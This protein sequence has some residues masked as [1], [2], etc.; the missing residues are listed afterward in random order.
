MPQGC[1]SSSCVT[2]LLTQIGGLN[3]GASGIALDGGGN[4]YF[5]NY[6]NGYVYELPLGCASSSCVTTLGSGFG[7]PANLAV[8]GSGNVY[9]AAYCI[10][11]NGCQ[12]VKEIDR[13]TP[14]ALNFPTATPVGSVDTTD[15]TQTVQI[16]NVGSAA[17]AFT[18]L[19]YPADFSE[20]SGDASACTGSTSLSAGQEC[21]LAI[22]FAPEKTGAPLSEDVTLTD[23]ALN[24]TGAQQ[25]VAVSGTSTGSI[26][27]THLSLSAPANAGVGA[28]FSITVTALDASGGTATGYA[29]TVSFTSTDASAV[30][31]A[32]SKLTAG[33][34][35][36]PVTLKTLGNQTITAA[37][38]ANSFTATSGTIDVGATPPGVFP[39]QGSVNFGSQAIGSPSGAQT[40]SFSIGAGTTVGSIAVVTQGAANLDFTQATGSTCTAT[41]YSSGATCV[42]N[43][44]FTPKFAGIRYGAVV[45]GDG[46]GNVLATEY[47]LGTGT[48]PQVTFLPGTESTMGIGLSSPGQLAVD[49]SGNVYLTDNYSGRILKETS[50]GGGYTQ[51]VILT[52]E[53]VGVLNC[54][55]AVAV[56]GAGNVYVGFGLIS[57]TYDKSKILKMTPSASGY[58]LSTIG[59][60]LTQAQGLVVDGNGNV[61]IADYISDGSTGRVVEE[62]LSADGTYTQSVVLTAG[63]GSF[64]GT[65]SAVAVDANGN[66]FVSSYY[67]SQV[68]ELT[69]SSG[70][71]TQSLIGSGLNWPDQMVT[72][73]EGNLYIADGNNSRIVKETLMAGSYVQSTVS[74]SGTSHPWGVAV[75]Q[76]GNV[77]ASDTYNARLLKEDLADA[78]SLSFATTAVGSTS[79]DSPKTAQ[80]LNYGNE[81]LALTALTYPV[82]FPAASGDASACTSSTSLSAGQECDLPIEFVPE[83]VGSPLSEDVTLTDNALNV[84]GAQQSIAVSGTAT[85]SIVA[86]HLSVSAPANVG[87]GVP[88]NVTVTALD[89]SGGTATGYTGT[90]S[91]TSTDASA[92]LPAASKLTAGVGSFPVTLKT[93][94]NQTITAKDAANAFTATSGTI[95]VG[96]TPPTPGPVPVFG[97]GYVTGGPGLAP[98]GTADGNYQLLSCPAGACGTKP[99]VTLTDQYPFNGTWFANTATA[100]WIGP[101]SG[102]NEDQVDSPGLYDYQESF[103][104]TGFD[105]NTVTLTGSYATDNQGYMQLNGVTAGPA[106]PSFTS[107]T[108]FTLTSGFNQ[109]INTL[110]FFVTNGPTGGLNPTGLFVELSGT[111]AAA[112]I[113]ATHFSVTTTTSVVAGS[114]F[115]IT[116]SALNSYGNAATT[117]N[118][119][120]SFTSSDP[121][122]VNPGPLTLA[123]GLGQTTVTLKTAGTQTITATDTTT[124]TLTG[125]GSFTVAGGVA[126]SV[127]LSN[128]Q[129]LA[130]V[131]GAFPFTVTAFD[132]YGNAT[133]AQVQFSSTDAGAILPGTSTL[134]PGP[135]IIS[136]TLVTT[137][138]QTITV[139]DTAN[140]S[141][142][143]TSGPILVKTP[144]LVVTTAADDA[145]VAGNCTLQA[146]TTTGTDAA[147]SLRDALLKANAF[148]A[149]IIS[150]DATKFATPQTITL[151]SAGTLTIS[152]NTSITGP[153]TGAGATLTNL[154]TVSGAGKHT[155]FTVTPSTTA[156][157]LNDLTI[158]HGASP[159]VGGGGINNQGSITVNNSTFSGNTAEGGQG[160]AIYNGNN[161]AVNNSTFVG[162]TANGTGGAGGAIYNA[163]GWSGL[164]MT[165]NDSTFTGN[166]STCGGAIYDTAGEYNLNLN[167]D[168][169]VG[170]T[171]GCAGGVYAQVWEDGPDDIGYNVDMIN[172]IVSGNTSPDVYGNWENLGGNLV[173]VGN[174]GLTPLANYGGPT[175]TMIP[176]P[177][178]PAI[179]AGWGVEALAEPPPYWFDPFFPGPDQRGFP[180][181][182]FCN[183]GPSWFVDSGSV[184]TSYAIAFITEPP[185]SY[186]VGLPLQPAPVVQLTESGVV[187]PVPT[188]TVTMTDSAGLLGGTTTA[189]FASGSATF[190][191][192]VVTAP[193]SNDLLTA[194]LAVG[195]AANLTA[196]SGPIQVSAPAADTLYIPA[197]GSVLQGPEVTFT[198]TP[199]T[200]ATGYSLWI[201]TTGV[202]SHDLY[203]SGE[204][205][206]TSRKVGGLPTN[207]ETLYV[208]LNTTSGKVTVHSDYSFTA[209]TRAA[210]ISPAGGSAL[211]GS[212]VTFTWSAAAGASGYSLWLSSVGPGLDDLFDSKETNGTSATAEGLPTGGVTIYARLYTTYRNATVYNDSTFIAF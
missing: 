94:G 207:G 85:G 163:L 13:A 11:S 41:G 112:T 53:N 38:A 24:V 123:S 166:E 137:G 181:N 121:M 31:P 186:P 144:Y 18:G 22:E 150:F 93:L 92:V 63:T 7:N 195:Y 193:A 107:L 15:G 114:P 133:I 66:L 211:G 129:S 172:A 54:P 98:V 83:N 90:V 142:K 49:G 60:G 102:G 76:L 86:T 36:F 19:S 208:R 203:D 84:S 2:T 201:G 157:T 5:T 35:T 147:C 69:P 139:T 9:I 127:Q 189:N 64:L 48:G 132:A 161:L 136:A 170:N 185:S 25:S 153:T 200:G 17:L 108:P 101:D 177:G 192:L 79:S 95:D 141:I 20:A 65:P 23:N 45:F 72:D 148:G 120:V 67:L 14:P 89:A 128:I 209:T 47:L 143:A 175:Q 212:T 110:D 6:G 58:T 50:S 4:I 188:S 71:Y 105:L 179:C 106:S 183:G 191:N 46:S 176:L 146:T 164:T 88:F 104:L 37:D 91:F 51:S 68:I 30:L 199:L 184:Q 171:G 21:D 156:A 33:V 75:D 80:I 204:W 126:V 57:T 202:G 61:F 8:D 44:I 74:T 28:A 131:D 169:I 138:I 55:E 182:Q 125:A 119:T 39:A 162:N 3:A 73:G 155:V 109:G 40:L 97:T 87:A 59:S 113:A 100:Q 154:L 210:M 1:V 151:G 134:P 173:G 135:E 118:G 168:T 187:A 116:V 52:C 56:D 145:G 62:V 124:S 29:G 198:W 205:A 34:G 117:Y 197:P 103:D 115:T 77:Y 12:A 42:V 140:S 122:F 196:Q 160:G 70:G 165:V 16:Q 194:T 158:A 26:V 206:V 43:V 190:G 82:D 32:A 174:P 81:A 130:Y 99:F 96:A 111:G 159:G 178:G 180:L 78:P 152:S 167:A 27:A 10:P 149:G